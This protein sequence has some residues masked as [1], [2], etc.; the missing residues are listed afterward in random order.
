MSAQ[1]SQSVEAAREEFYR[2][3]EP[4]S[5]NPLWT[6]LL[7]KMTQEPKRAEIPHLWR[8]NDVRPQLL[9]A[10]ELITAE[11]AERRVLIFSN[12][13]DPTRI[14][15]TATLYAAVQ[16]I[17]PG[18]SAPAHRH[19]PSAIRFIIEGEGAFTCVD[20]ENIT[21]APGDLVLTPPGVW[22]D[23]GNDTQAP[24][25]WLDGLDI[26]YMLSLN[27]MFFEGHPDRVQPVDK[28][29][30]GS[31]KLY[32]RAF[33]PADAQAS[34][35]PPHCS[36]VMTYRF[37]QAREALECLRSS[38]KPD[39]FDCYRLRYAN[40]ANGGDVLPTMGCGLQLLEKGAA[41]KSHRHTISTVYHVVEG[42]GSSLI[43]GERFEWS[44]GDTFAVP[45]WC[46]HEHTAEDEAVLFSINDEPI[47]RAI[48]QIRTETKG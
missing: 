1:Q 6:V 39:P 38:S 23:H 10:G 7:P 18:E 48:G 14:G 42:C 36:P 17:L 45:T 2:Q 15:A 24:V 4:H 22:H 25:I 13:G 8:W 37:Q 31:E 44:P 29:E 16:L 5:L 33:F 11:E 28:P 9:R 26:P 43:D 30:R 46:W 32:G 19:S 20:G 40:P 47:L 3:L 35:S 27:C 34:T 41:T 12:P 21:M